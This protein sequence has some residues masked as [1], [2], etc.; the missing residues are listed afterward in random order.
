MTR[1]A[2]KYELG[3]LL[4]RGSRWDVLAVEGRDDLVV[5]SGTQTDPPDV[6]RAC[7]ADIAALAPIFDARLQGVTARILR[8]HHS[9]I[10]DFFDASAV[11]KHVTRSLLLDAPMT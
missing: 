5:N 11:L 2:D 7:R 1:L 4:H 3:V 9:G 8:A 6:R 10:R